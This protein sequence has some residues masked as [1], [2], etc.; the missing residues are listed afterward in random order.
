MGVNDKVEMSSELEF[1]ASVFYCIMLITRTLQI[2]DEN[3]FDGAVKFARDVGKRSLDGRHTSKRPIKDAHLA[4]QLAEGGLIWCILPLFSV[5]RWKCV[6]IF[7]TPAGSAFQ[8]L[9]DHFFL[10][11][12]VHQGEP[13]CCEC[14]SIW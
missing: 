13:L 3:F 1:Y 8:F 10:S 12:V 6:T 4:P 14:Q 11:V 5:Y 7:D 2:L 9:V